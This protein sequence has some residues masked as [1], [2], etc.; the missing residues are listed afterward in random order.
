MREIIVILTSVML[1]SCKS[2][3]KADSGDQEKI[4]L[5]AEEIEEITRNW[6]TD[7]VG[8]LRLRDPKKM[9]DLT[10][11]L[12]LVG[13]DSTKALE[14]LGKPNASYGQGKDRHFLYFLE[15][16]QGKTSYYN[17]YCHLRADT[18]HSFTEAVY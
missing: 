2:D 17:F 10:V 11:H 8:C 6:K 16:G 12:K 9:K 3:N 13:K 4:E 15:C 1:L 7:S 5:T 18:I 14:Y